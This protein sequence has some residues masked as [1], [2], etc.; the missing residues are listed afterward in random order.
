MQEVVQE[1]AHHANPVQT[2]VLFTIVLLFFSTLVAMLTKKIKMPFTVAL[3]GFGIL[4]G[5]VQQFYAEITHWLPFL[6]SVGWIER[7]M[8]FLTSFQLT[9]EVV[10][11]VFLPALLF[12]AAFNLDARRL[13]KNII[14]VLFLAIPALLISTFV[15]GY[16]VHW[17]L[18]IPLVYSLLFGAL[19]SATDPVAVLGIFKE[20]GAPKRLSILVEGESLFNDGTA[21]VVFGIIVGIIQTGVFTGDTIIEGIG[22]FAFVFLGGI[23]LGLLAGFIFSWLVGTVKEDELTEITLTAILPYFI[24]IAAEHFFHVSGVMATVVAALVLGSYGRTKISPSVVG[25]MHGFWEMMAFIANSLIFLLVGLSLNLRIFAENWPAMLIIIAVVTFARALAIYSSV[26]IVNLLPSVEKISLPYQTIMFWGG[27]RGALAIAM[28]LAIPAGF[29]YRDELILF[30]GAIVLFTLFAA[31]FTIEGLLRVLGLQKLSRVE[32]YERQ[33][34]I[35]TARTMASRELNSLR[36]V[37]YFAKKALNKAISDEK[38]AEAKARNEL[39]SFKRKSRITTEE[40]V[41]II[42]GHCFSIEKKAY[43]ELFAGGELDELTMGDLQTYADNLADRIRTGHSPRHEAGEDLA[44][45]IME[46]RFYNLAKKLPFSGPF[47]RRYRSRKLAKMY[48]RELGELM[49]MDK[50]Y[51]ELKEMRKAGLAAAPVF[52]EVQSFYNT[53]NKK[54]LGRLRLLENQ[55]PAYTAR[56]QDYL[57]ERAEIKSELA[58]FNELSSHGL[59]PDAVLKE[60][61]QEEEARLASLSEASAKDL[62]VDPAKLLGKIPLFKGFGPAQVKKLASYLT[63]QSYL[64]GEY[65]MR[66]GEVGTSMYLIGSGAVKVTIGD[67]TDQEQEVAQLGA[68]NFVGEIALLTSGRRTAN[69]ITLVPSNLLKLEKKDFNRFLDQNPALRTK[70]Q[71]EAGKRLGK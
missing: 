4:I 18:H 24:F 55:F 32:A 47:I 23:L 51:A 25:H 26:P 59:L 11:N 44:L 50:V 64:D 49:A 67:R 9:P 68:G 30:T 28:A 62:A 1:A 20:L 70:I 39:Q 13:L 71:K 54:A 48:E 12:E 15:V 37:G 53:R 45:R 69:I 33:T 38:Q 2:M 40:E 42:L 8:H 58:A 56:V 63:T 43:Q 22:S 10:L 36:S 52:K 61:L 29:Q 7:L 19:I 34:G 17:L 65:V 35:L 41:K 31:G 14:P 5:V 6:E 46:R 21:L 66:Q 3:F 57:L 60:M 16:L 27:M